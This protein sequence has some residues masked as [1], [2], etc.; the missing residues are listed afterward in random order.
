M[1]FDKGSLRAHYGG[2]YPLDATLGTVAES[3]SV[4]HTAT[5]GGKNEAGEKTSVETTVQR[6]AEMKRKFLAEGGEKKETK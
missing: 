5:Y 4:T 1:T 6:A 2:V 3:M